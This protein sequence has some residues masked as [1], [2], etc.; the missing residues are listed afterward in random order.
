[1]NISF[2]AF[3]SSTVQWTNKTVADVSLPDGFKKDGLKALIIIV[4]RSSYILF[5]SSP[6]Q[7]TWV[8]P[9]TDNAGDAAL[10]IQTLNFNVNINPSNNT[11]KANAAYFGITLIKTSSSFG[12]AL[13]ISNGPEI[14]N[15]SISIQGAI[16]NN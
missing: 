11:I 8:S 12:S 1:M 9:T 3:S 7:H 6:V 13:A 5:P 15:A 16:Y 10:N 14:T 4:Y 2:G